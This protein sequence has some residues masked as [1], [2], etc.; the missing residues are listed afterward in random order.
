MRKL[1]KLAAAVMTLPIVVACSPTPKE[2][3]N[4][5]QENDP[6]LKN[7]D[8]TLRAVQVEL[9][10]SSNTVAVVLT[11]GSSDLGPLGGDTRPVTMRAF[12]GYRADGANPT[13]T[14]AYK[15]TPDDNKPD[16]NQPGSKR[17]SRI[18]FAPLSRIP[19]SDKESRI[20]GIC[21]E[22]TGI[23]PGKA[24]QVAALLPR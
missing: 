23:L 20:L 17:P 5:V 24:T 15:E 4:C 18:D 22:A 14:V 1:V 8:G 11:S 13:V 12:D 6:A 16:D 7:L 19:G 9:F 2:F 21:L 3:V 10:R